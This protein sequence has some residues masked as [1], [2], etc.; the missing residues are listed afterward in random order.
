MRRKAELQASLESD[1]DA[2]LADVESDFVNKSAEADLTSLFKSS[3]AMDTIPFELEDRTELIRLQQFDPDL[4]SLFEMSNK[5][6]K[7]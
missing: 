4:S 5:G 7:A 6:D 1:P 3:V 2:S